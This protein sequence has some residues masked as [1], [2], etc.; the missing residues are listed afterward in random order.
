MLIT[1]ELAISNLFNPSSFL[2]SLKIF[3][4]LAEFADFN[5]LIMILTDEI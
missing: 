4:I 3:P 1:N 2:A 5:S